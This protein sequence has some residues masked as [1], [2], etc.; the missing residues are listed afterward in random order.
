MFLSTTMRLISSVAEVLEVFNPRGSELNIVDIRL[1]SWLHI[2]TPVNDKGNGTDAKRR[3][4]NDRQDAHQIQV[5]IRLKS[6]ES[7]INSNN[8]AVIRG[9]LDTVDALIEWLLKKGEYL[10]RWCDHSADAGTQENEFTATVLRFRIGSLVLTL[11][12]R[13]ELY[14]QP[15]L[16][17]GGVMIS[18][19]QGQMLTWFE[20]GARVERLLHLCIGEPG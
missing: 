8:I 11:D 2:L 14:H 12:Q 9:Q 1:S 13:V 16:L 6:L 20:T 3:R 18:T 7:A 5:Y 10:Y 15:D 17:A 19:V 4:T